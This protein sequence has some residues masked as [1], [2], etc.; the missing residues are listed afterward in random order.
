MGIWILH[1]K[2]VIIYITHKIRAQIFGFNKIWNWHTCLFK[3]SLGCKNQREIM[4]FVQSNNVIC[5]IKL[6]NF[7][8][9]PLSHTHIMRES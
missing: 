4:L 5:T 2:I 9:N 8:D 6:D 1:E 3:Y 7:L